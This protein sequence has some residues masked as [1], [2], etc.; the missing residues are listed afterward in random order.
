LSIWIFSVFGPFWVEYE[1]SREDGLALIFESVFEAGTG[2]SFGDTDRCEEEVVEL[3]L[4]FGEN[5]LD[6]GKEYLIVVIDNFHLITE[7]IFKVELVG[8]VRELNLAVVLKEQN[9]KRLMLFFFINGETAHDTAQN[10]LINVVIFEQIRFFLKD[11]LYH[12]LGFG[13]YFGLD[14]GLAADLLDAALCAGDYFLV[15]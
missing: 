8:I 11:E 4:I 15:N 1:N 5:I 9:L 10:N 13:D 2:E 6:F 7:L 14:W 12:V 3:V